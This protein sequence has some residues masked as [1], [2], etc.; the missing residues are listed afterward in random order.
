MKYFPFHFRT[1]YQTCHC[2]TQKNSNNIEKR[3]RRG[4]KKISKK[5]MFNGLIKKVIICLLITRRQISLRSD[6]CVL[7]NKNLFK[8]LLMVSFDSFLIFEEIK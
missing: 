7:V 6:S 5:K 1:D 2:S 3:I 8:S 4:G